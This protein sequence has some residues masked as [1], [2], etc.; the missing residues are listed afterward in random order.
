[1]GDWLLKR[2]QIDINLDI[3]KP[4]Q[5]FGFLFL[6]YLFAHGGVL[7]VPNAIFWDDWALFP[8]DKEHNTEIFRQLGRFLNLDSYIHIFL[9]SIGPW[10]YKVLTF[11]LMFGTGIALDKVLKKHKFI[12]LNTRFLIV[13]FF[14][15]MPFYWGRMSLICM[16]YTISYFLFFLAWAIIDKYRIISLS[17]FFL[18]FN[19]NSLLVFYALPILDYYIR[20]KKDNQVNQSF[21]IECI[22]KIDFLLLPF[23][24]FAI[25]ITVFEPTG[26]YEGYNEQYMLINLLKAPFKM[27][28]DWGGLKSPI[29]FSIILALAINAFVRKLFDGEIKLFPRSS[30]Y[31]F[32]SGIFSFVLAGFPYWILGH[33]PTFSEWTSRHQ[34]L[35]PL[36]GALILVSILTSSIISQIRLNS[37]VIAIALCGASNMYTYKD[38]YFDWQKQKE[39][40]YYLKSDDLALNA[41][42]VVFDDRA[43]TFNA[44]NRTL[45]FYEWNGILK[46]SFGN[47]LRHGLNLDQFNDYKDGKNLKWPYKDQLSRPKDYTRSNNPK[48]VLITISPNN[49]ANYLFGKGSLIEIETSKLFNVIIDL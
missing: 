47:E 46:Y 15:I 49:F 7:L 16:P 44:I 29:I 10:T 45:R 27:F 38:F 1:M 28:L 23:V 48:T 43:N 36:G 6:F 18:S 22:K 25:K 41:D 19:T 40:I 8:L 34:L 42:L 30:F 4:A 37:I 32:L 39:L 2:S 21:L 31:L 3:E 24:F 9:L 12:D 20:L 33:V 26:D 14:M 11:I 35:F 13:L 17:L 5:Y